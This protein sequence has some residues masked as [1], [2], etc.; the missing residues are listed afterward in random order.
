MQQTT[1]HRWIGIAHVKPSPKYMEEIPEGAV[2]AFVPVVADANTAEQF[3]QHVYEKLENFMGFPII[4]ISDIDLF[5]STQNIDEH[6][7]D[8]IENLL[9]HFGLAYG[10]F[11]FYGNQ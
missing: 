7:C 4:E 2:G 11:Q 8:S 10:D 6:L 1:N 9:P 3:C 5:C